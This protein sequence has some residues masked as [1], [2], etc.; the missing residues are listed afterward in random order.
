M[1]SIEVKKNKALFYFFSWSIVFLFPLYSLP[2]VV[3]RMWRL[4]K[5]A[6]I[7]FAFFMGLLGL[8]YAPT[9]DMYMYAKDYYLYKGLDWNT[10]IYVVALEH[11]DFLLS[12]ISY[13]FGL[14]GLSNDLVRFLYNFVAYILLGSLFLKIV[15]TNSSY[16][17]KTILYALFILI[18]FILIRYAFRF[19]LS[20]VVFVYGAYLIICE[21]KRKGWIFVF[22]A[23]LNHLSFVLYALIVV[24]VKLVK[25]SFSIL[26]IFLLGIIAF[27]MSTFISD[28]FY[29]LPIS[30]EMMIHFSNY[31][32]GY[33]ADQI[34]KDKTN[35]DLI[36]NSISYSYTALLLLYVLSF[37]NKGGNMKK[38]LVAYMVLLCII[39]MPY[40]VMFDRFL[41]P[42]RLY[43]K[44]FILSS[45]DGSPRM[46]RSLKVFFICTIMFSVL[47][48]WS[49]RRQ[50]FVSDYSLLFTSTS[51]GIL[52]HTYPES[53]INKNVDEIG[54][55][56]NVNW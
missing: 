8:L 37:Y 28:I 26:T 16:K 17:H 13:I 55:L 20:S 23:V 19:G 2:W 1:S 21:E 52:C 51:L 42:L 47:N 14:I 6:F 24:L 27:L 11:F 39:S 30:P 35:K 45:F 40:A 54:G 44:V 25:K 36:W 4:E 56:I 5:V 38:S 15:R 34:L 29:N 12:L 18:N 46:I 31:I 50:I 22:L 41:I 43:L 53:W 33:Q 48:T 3:Y 7:Q 9:G 10:F 49:Y 32:D